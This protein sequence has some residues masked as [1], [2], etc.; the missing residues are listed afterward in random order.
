[1]C[2]RSSKGLRKT[3][4]V[5]RV[6]GTLIFAVCFLTAVNAFGYPVPLPGTEPIPE[7]MQEASLV[8]KG[9][10]TSAPT[11]TLG[12]NTPRM[13][14]TAWVRL[15][16]CFKGDVGRSPIPLAVD[17]YYALGGGP[18]FFLKPGDYRVLFLTPKDGRYMIVNEWFGSLKASRNLSSSGRDADT[19]MASLE[20][21]LV[22][23]L[24]DKDT[25]LVLENIRMLGNMRALHSTVE[26]KSFL[27]DRD[28][29]V[30]TYVWQALLRL[31]DYSVLSAV[32]EFFASQPLLPPSLILPRD[33]LF[34]MQSELV[35]EIGGIRSS[36]AL[37]FLETFAVSKEPVLRRN[38]LQAI[39]QIRSAHSIPV[40]LNELDDSDRHN[41]FSAMQGL[42]SLRSA[43]SSTDWVPTMKEFL[44]S[45]DLWV[46]KTR[47]WWDVEGKPGPP[48]SSL[49]A[50]R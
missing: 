6:S 20:R 12:D 50:S 47:Q 27:G 40:L 49:P 34:H 48:D 3:L 31:K 26:L 17:Q 23:G 45:P 4:A 29:I 41:S 43:N 46:A 2:L 19:P 18:T 16:R 13:S 30:R 32:A 35:Q 11:P 21:D 15:D 9:E 14:G 33:W 39:R 37:P 44:Q 24:Q 36:E 22:A 38:A 8:C 42:L 28:P 25:E 1:M 10:V 7:M 5:K